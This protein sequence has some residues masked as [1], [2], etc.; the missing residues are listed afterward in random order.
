MI[1]AGPPS[2]PGYLDCLP[3][4]GAER[5]PEGRGRGVV[6]RNLASQGV[7]GH[8]GAAPLS[9]GQAGPTCTHTC[10]RLGRVGVQLGRVG[11]IAGRR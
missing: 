8:P 3:F 6:R 9:L 2:G 4:G 7:W 11:L 10:K 5:V 1:P